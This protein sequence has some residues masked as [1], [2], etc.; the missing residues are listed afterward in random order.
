MTFFPDQS[1]ICTMIGSCR[2]KFA[3]RLLSPNDNATTYRSNW[4]D[5]IVQL[6]H[7]T[8][9]PTAGSFFALNLVC[10]SIINAHT[11]LD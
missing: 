2:K 5:E 1:C 7:P 6:P 9:P 11:A 10:R 3:A 8:K 4:S